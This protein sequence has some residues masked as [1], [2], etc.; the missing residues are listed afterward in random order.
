[1]SFC[2]LAI[3]LLQGFWIN[4]FY[5]QKA[6][7]FSKTVYQTL[8]DI[9]AKLNE[10]ENIKYVKETILPKH[11]SKIIKKGGS[12]QVIV[13][14]ASTDIQDI[15]GDLDIIHEL[16]LDS[17]FANEDHQIIV[18]DSV[19]R[20]NKG[21]RMV[22]VNKNSASAS[23][24]SKRKEIDKLLNKMLT[25][26]KTIEVTP[27]EDFSPDS[28]KVFIS[29]A[30]ETKGVFT[31]FE[32]LLQRET[33]HTE[34]ILAKSS[35]FD[36]KQKFYKG[37]LSNNKIFNNHNY[38]YLQFP[39]EDSFVFS[40]MKNILLLS[41]LFSLITML[42]FFYTLRLILKQKKLSEVKNDFINNMTHELKTPI[43]TISLAI[44]AI[45]NPQVKYDDERFH[46]YTS[47]LREENQ[48]LNNH[49]EHVL[50]LAL[51]DKGELQIHKTKVDIIPLI[52]SVIKA[53]K[54]LISKQN[55]EVVFEPSITELMIQADEYHLL[56]MFNNLLDNALKYS[57]SNCRIEIKISGTINEAIISFKDN[58]IGIDPGL[59][60]RIFEKFFRV[61]TGN[62]HDVKGFGLGLSYV[63]SIIEKHQ[64]SIELRSEKGNGSEFIIKLPL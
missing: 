8:S 40:R 35:A 4:H 6:E 26:I 38:L 63:K 51:L 23:K 24:A 14:S 52:N 34:N 29:K 33:L 13:S 39:D 58:G 12:V 7:E 16:T 31:P 50:Q 22:I 56:S 41:G 20:I 5:H 21:K 1:M 44:D 45:S 28:L 30:F 61:Q 17:A 59:H 27:I 54:L 15:P 19:V 37:D 48:K 2:L 10:R 57:N 49:V 25:E 60:K 43:A 46:K 3:L 64:G 47:I 42:A 32:F 55:A 53:H 62:I 36:K 18:S 9:S 11:E